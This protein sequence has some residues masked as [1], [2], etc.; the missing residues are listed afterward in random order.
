[1]RSDKINIIEDLLSE[2][3][4]VMNSNDY[5]ALINNN[6]SLSLYDDI[7][8]KIDDGQAPANYLDEISDS[9]LDEIISYIKNYLKNK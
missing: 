6:T 2:A 1:M 5:L 9:S 4:Q 8:K 3:L 7:S